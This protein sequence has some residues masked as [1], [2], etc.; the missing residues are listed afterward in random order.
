MRPEVVH[1]RPQ[2]LYGTSVV[3][4]YLGR[5][6]G[7]SYNERFPDTPANRASEVREFEQRLRRFPS[8]V[9]E[10]TSA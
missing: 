1:I 9:A 2:G 3:I 4:S 8:S 5:F 6:F 10:E 7:S